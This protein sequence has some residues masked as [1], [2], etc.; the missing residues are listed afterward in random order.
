MPSSGS[1]GSTFQPSCAIAWRISPRD[2]SIRRITP[3]RFESGSTL[4]GSQL[5]LTTRLVSAIPGASGSLSDESPFPK[6]DGEAS[7]GAACALGASGS[8]FPKNSVPKTEALIASD[9][10]SRFLA[11]GISPSWK[12]LCSSS[13][14]SAHSFWVSTASCSMSS[15]DCS[16]P[17]ANP[18]AQLATSAKTTASRSSTIATVDLPATPAESP[19]AAET[20]PT[21]AGTPASLFMIDVRD[22]A[23][24]KCW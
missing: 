12:F 15:D 21:A 16:L 13:T 5:T 24:S 22:S 3:K 6:A 23:D 10:A 14:I 19:R 2:L 1:T 8:L 11:R 4:C 20:K 7:G 9:T 17:V 18:A